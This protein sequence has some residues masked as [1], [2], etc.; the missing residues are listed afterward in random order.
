MQKHR[1]L[2]FLSIKITSVINISKDKI[3]RKHQKSIKVSIYK[4][5]AK[6]RHGVFWQSKLQ[7]WL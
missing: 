3:Y 4:I 5:I 2:N 6:S 1:P 7:K